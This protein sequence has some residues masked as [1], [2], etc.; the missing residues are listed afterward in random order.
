MRRG[1]QGSGER[2]GDALDLGR[3]DDERRRDLEGDAAQQPGD[4]AAL[5]DGTSAGAPQALGALPQE[6]RQKTSHE[7]GTIESFNPAAEKIFG[8]SASEVLG[9]NVKMLMPEPHRT[10]HDGYLAECLRTAQDKNIGVVREV[11]GRRE[12]QN[13][14]VLD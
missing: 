11:I 5:A 14:V 7:R 4:H 6:V 9:R 12:R 10:S 3:G 2:L 13:Q 8:Y 1:V